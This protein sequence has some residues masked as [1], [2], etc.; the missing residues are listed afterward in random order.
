MYRPLISICMPVYNAENYVGQAIEGIL[1]QT[2]DHYE[3]VVCDNCST[4]SSAEIVQKYAQKYP[5]VRF[6]QNQWN[7]GFSGNAHKTTSLAKGDFLL[8]HAADDIAAPDAL[9]QY[10]KVLDEADTDPQHTILMSDFYVVNEHGIEQRIRTWDSVFVKPPGIPRNIND[11]SIIEFTGYNILASRLPNLATFGWVG[12]I[13]F[14]KKLLVDTEGYSSNQW[15][16]PD[17]HFMIKLLSLNP[18]VFWIKSPLFFYRIH[19]SNQ[20][21]QQA[22]AG[23]LKYLL[24]QYAYTFDLPDIMLRQYVRDRSSLVEYFIEHDCMRA[25]LREIALGR[26]KLGFRH[27]CFGLATYPDVAWRNYKTH[28]ALLLWALGPI[29]KLI[30]RRLYGGYTARNPERFERESAKVMR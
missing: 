16:N 22:S 27:L 13:L 6:Y 24:D 28:A 18:T 17:K 3:I 8:L 23:V 10:V 1:A 25:A 7:I 15:I 11:V 20:N 14:S 12:T 9:E 30:G 4:D 19:D 2:Y 5:Q 26:R 21:A 29:G